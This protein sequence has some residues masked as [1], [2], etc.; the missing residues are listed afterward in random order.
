MSIDDLEEMGFK[1]L[2]DNQQNEEAINVIDENLF[3][4]VTETSGIN[5]TPEEPI[6]FRSSSGFIFNIY[7]SHS[8]VKMSYGKK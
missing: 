8:K 7:K 2:I 6:W 3:N 5:M 1:L 4:E